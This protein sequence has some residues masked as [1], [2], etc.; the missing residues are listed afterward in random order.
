M[1]KMFKLILLEASFLKKTLIVIFVILTAFSAA[2]LAVVSVLADTPQGMLSGLNASKRHFTDAYGGECFALSAKNKTVA[3]AEELD[4]ELCYGVVKGVTRDVSLVKGDKSFPTDIVTQLGDGEHSME[5]RVERH[6][7]FVPTEYADK[8]PFSAASSGVWLS[9]QVA[10]ELEAAA[11]DTVS[12]GNKAYVVLGVY[13]EADVKRD[14]GAGAVL[15]YSRF[16][17]VDEASSFD[18][19][20]LAYGTAEKLYGVWQSFKAQTGL[21]IHSVITDCYENISLVTS[22]YGALAFLLA[23]LI[24]F[25]MCVFFT[26]LYRLRKGHICRFKLLGATNA[27][28]AGIYLTIAL[29]ISIAA[30]VCAAA[31]SVLLS[32]HLLNLCTSLFGVSY[33]YHFRVWI[34][35]ALLGVFV[36][37]S[38]VM[39]ALL[40]RRISKTPVA[41]EVRCE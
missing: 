16:Y 5:Y 6:G 40:Q 17:V 35:C 22:Y 37:L 11:D 2:F 39:F 10:T 36:V 15:P 33:G 32:K 21:K 38:A 19:I 23:A 18:T 27:T 9:D 8:L 3:L 7:Y 28:I 1:K 13:S 41:E 25:L 4:A 26:L 30:V 29:V 20:Y 31:L 14:Y 12:I 34:P 24:L